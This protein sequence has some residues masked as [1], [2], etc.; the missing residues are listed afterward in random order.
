MAD[1]LVAGVMILVG[2]HEVM[3]SAAFVGATCWVS[4]GRYCVFLMDLAMQ[5]VSLQTD[6]NGVVWVAFA[7]LW[8]V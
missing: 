7:R 1:S 6:I 4:G 8:R 2:L 3:I 5:R